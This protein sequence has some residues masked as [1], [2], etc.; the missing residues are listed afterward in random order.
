MLYGILQDEN[1]Y[2]APDMDANYKVIPGHFLTDFRDTLQDCDWGEFPDLTAGM[3]YGPDRSQLDEGYPV[4]YVLGA[5]PSFVEHQTRVNFTGDFGEV[6][7][8]SLEQSFPKEFLSNIYVA[9]SLRV[10]NSP[11]S[12]RTKIQK[13]FFPL[14]AMELAVLQPDHII[15]LGSQALKTFT[16]KSQAEVRDA[17]EKYTFPIVSEDGVPAQKT[18][19]VHV[20][21][22]SAL[23]SY[24]DFRMFQTLMKSTSY[25]IQNGKCKEQQ[26]VTYSKI[27]TVEGLKEYV[28]LILRK[29]ETEPVRV[30]IDLEWHGRFVRNANCYVRTINMS[31]DALDSPTTA[32]VVLTQPGGEWTFNG[33]KEDLRDLLQ[34]LFSPDNKVQIV[35]HNFI[36]DV[37]FLEVLGVQVKQKFVFPDLDSCDPDYPG[38]FDTI[39]AY[40]AID[41]CGQFGLDR[42]ARIWLDIPGWAGNLEAFLKKQKEK[43]QGYGLIPEDILLPYAAMDAYATLK[44]SEELKKALK[45]DY[46]GNNCWK[47]YWINLRAQPAFL[48][49]YDTGVLIDTDRAR[50]LARVYNDERDRLIQQF[51][52]EIAWPTFNVQSYPQCV[53]LLYGEKYTGKAR[54]RPEG[55]RSFY[56]T[57]L[58]TTDG[59]EWGSFC[60]PGKVSPSTDMDTIN[61]LCAIHPELKTLRNIKALN[62]I[63]KTVLP[64]QENEEDEEGGILEYV[65]DDGKIHPSYIALKETRRC[66]SARPNL[67]NLPN[68]EEDNYKTILGDKYVAPI[69]SIIVAPDSY[70]LVEIDYSGAELLLIGVAAGDRNLIEDYYRSVLPDDHPDKLDIHSN[71]AVLAFKLDCPPTKAGLKSVGKYHYRMAAKAIIF[72]LNY[73]RGVQ[74]CYFQLKTEGID[75]TKEDVQQVVDT[76]YT[77][78]S[79]VKDLQDAAKRRVHTH[80]W[81]ANCFGSYRRFFLTRAKDAV[82][83]MEREAMNFICQ[84]GVADAISMA[85]YNFYTHPA[86]KEV[87]YKFSMHNHDALLFVVRDE[88]D[89]L[90]RFVHQIVPECMQEGVKFQSCTLDGVPVPDSKWYRFELETKV[91]KRWAE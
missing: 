90:D 19:S 11:K 43:D 75:V 51:R 60:I 25:F 2:I 52:E 84:S 62:Q 6:L 79:R 7:L 5:E 36:A 3:W 78:Y 61:N 65:C 45:G 29:A 54:C 56:L 15:C 27:D 41:E 57:P 76:I 81:L 20:L 16:K 31:H 23:Q 40:H 28:S 87:D 18:A 46:Y 17:P 82:A 48:E 73:G 33:T 72:G 88:G 49:M 39:I 34:P 13:D 37:P 24:S 22:L 1:V 8:S 85:M 12:L 30:A 32:V 10:Y 69:R 70:K 66:S 9:N 44:L 91:G 58:K 53:E 74:S 77:R 64:V 26:E 50:E 68:S 21:P 14:I 89:N 55:A 80:K 71:I 4:L 63:T 67:Q 38:V 86:R 35:G 83:K 42:A 59:A 47:P